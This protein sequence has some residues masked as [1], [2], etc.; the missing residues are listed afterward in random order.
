MFQSFE[1]LE[2]AKL[3]HRM[4]TCVTATPPLVELG[5]E[6]RAGFDQ[7]VDEIIAEALER[8]EE[9]GGLDGWA[10]VSLRKLQHKSDLPERAQKVMRAF[11]MKDEN[12]LVHYFLQH[13]FGV[14]AYPDWM[15]GG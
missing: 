13:K 12:A 11:A 2:S 4:S 15:V 9:H 8:F 1:D 5:P 3:L 6:D 14:S 7:T 10:A